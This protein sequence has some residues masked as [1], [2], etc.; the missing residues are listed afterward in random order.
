MSARFAAAALRSSL[1]LS[2]PARAVAP[3]SRAT[4]VA[5]TTGLRSFHATRPAFVN[6]GDG[7]PEDIELAEG[8]PG[9]KVKLADE[10]RKANKALII[11]VPAAFSPS[12]SSVHV[13][14]YISHPRRSEFDF[15]AV[16]SVNDVFV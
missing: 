7:L 15:I 12:C 13:P 5:A 1:R 14:G 11:G 8:S 10:V 4:A 3:V 9:N 2:T 16:V 6:I